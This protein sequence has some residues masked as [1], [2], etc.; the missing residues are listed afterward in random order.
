MT[1]FAELNMALMLLILFIL[2]LAAQLFIYFNT[3]SKLAFYK[4]DNHPVDSNIP[5][6]VIIC[7]RNEGDNLTEYLPKI[8]SQDYPKFE[9]IVVN[10]CSY[11]N[12]D[13]VLREY[14]VIFPNL[15][16]ITVKEDEYYKHGKK[17][18]LM[19]GIKGAKYDHLLLTDADCVPDT[20]KWISTMMKA[21]SPGKEIVVGYGPYQ[22]KEGF[23]NKLIRYDTFVI[24]LQYLSKALRQQTYMGVGRNLSYKKELFFRHKG[25]SGHYHIASG[26]DDLFINQAAT[27]SNV[28][29][30]VDKN[31]FTYSVPS[32]NFNQWLEQKQRHLSTASLYKPATKT[33]LFFYFSVHYLFWMLFF[34]L[35]F[36][37]STLFIAL[38]VFLI[39]LTAQM[40]IFNNAMK[41]LNEKDL[42]PWT[43]IMEFI[44]LFMY[45]FFQI[46]GKF[47]KPN[48]W[49]R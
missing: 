29:V 42:L 46:S 10:D 33:G 36:F 18:A 9:V 34:A 20:E 32:K 4:E 13:D 27:A 12:T 21:Y 22:K 35:L 31:A 2:V 17:F 16:G 25:F 39:K 14:A 45:P 28:A 8:L 26:D 5:V 11:D 40:I 41:R 23:L 47:S 44:L 30:V 24:G 43:P 49:K 38:G 7:A 1:Y 19:V 3:F 6:S 15:R 48:K 37:K